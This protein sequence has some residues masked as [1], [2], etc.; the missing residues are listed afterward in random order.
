MTGFER[1]LYSD[2]E[3]DLDSV[4][5]ELVSRYQLLTPPDGREAP[6]WASKIHIAVAPVYYHTYLYGSI[7]GLQMR[8]ALS[9]AVGGIVDRP[10]AG[11]MLRQKLYGPGA[12]VRWD[13]LVEQA[14][15]SPL[16]VE[17]LA[18]AVAASS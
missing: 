8:D 6:D 15:G 13:Q 7:V 18:R 16:S 10:A 4:W 9:A 12:S 5:W 14:S 11:T 17:S 3:S 2:P 1:V